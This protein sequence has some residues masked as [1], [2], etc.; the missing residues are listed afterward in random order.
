MSRVPLPYPMRTTRGP[1][2]GCHPTRVWQDGVFRI[3]A[4]ILHLGNVVFEA[5]EDGALKLKGER[6]EFHLSTV[7]ELLG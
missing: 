5:T 2:H 6:E 7:V 1:S 4:A 3:L